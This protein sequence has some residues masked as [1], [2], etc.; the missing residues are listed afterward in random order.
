MSRKNDMSDL[1]ELGDKMLMNYAK[2][3]GED[4]TNRNCYERY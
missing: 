2:L 1:N 3:T 4:I